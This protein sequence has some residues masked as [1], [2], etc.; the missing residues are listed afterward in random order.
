M[1]FIMRVFK[2]SKAIF[3][4]L[5]GWS[6]GEAY[7]SN[8]RVT[9][10]QVELILQEPK[11]KLLAEV[12]VQLSDSA[13]GALHSGI[14]LYWDISI[15][16]QQ[17]QW[18]GFWQREVFAQTWR[19]SLAYYTLLNNYRVQEEQEQSFRR[20]SSLHEALNYMGQLMYADLLMQEYDSQRCVSWALNVAFDREALPTPLRP[21]SYFDQEWDLS[22]SK[23]LL[24]E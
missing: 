19:Y 23:S 12:Q 11:A 2:S 20:F 24:C 10:K 5:L 9:V 21:F 13:Q 1:A 18:R 4:I 3:F 17:A 7:A 16:L 14:P 8:E 22:A 6:L 15:V